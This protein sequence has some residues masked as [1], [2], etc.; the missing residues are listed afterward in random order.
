MTVGGEQRNEEGI[1]VVFLSDPSDIDNIWRISSYLGFHKTTSE[2]RY[3]P[4]KWL[5]N[6]LG[7]T[8]TNIYDITFSTPDWSNCLSPL[9]RVSW[10]ILHQLENQLKTSKNPL[11][12]ISKGLGGLIVKQ[13]CLCAPK[14]PQ[15]W[16]ILKRLAGLVFYSCPHE[17][18]SS[19]EM[20]EILM[21]VQI[22]EP[23]D[24]LVLA[25]QSL[26][27]LNDEFKELLS[28]NLIFN[29][30]QILSFG[31]ASKLSSAI[32]P[33]KISKFNFGDNYSLVGK[34]FSNITSVR[35]PEDFGYWK[36]LTLIRNIIRKKKNFQENK[37]EEN[38]QK[39]NKNINFNNL[40][41]N[42]D[43]RTL[44]II[45]GDYNTSD[46]S[47]YKIIYQEIHF[48]SLFE[49]LVKACATICENLQTPIDKLSNLIKEKKIKINMTGIKFQIEVAKFFLLYHLQISPESHTLIKIDYLN[50]SNEN[51]SLDSALVLEIKS[52]GYKEQLLPHLNKLA[53]L[54]QDSK[55]SVD[56]I[57]RIKDILNQKPKISLLGRPNSGK[58]TLINGLCG[59][60]WFSTASS[61]CTGTVS[62]LHVD[63]APN[64]STDPCIDLVY[65]S[66]D[67]L[68]SSVTEYVTQYLQRG[69]DNDDLKNI[70]K[71]FRDKYDEL[72][73]ENQ[74]NRVQRLS[75]KKCL[76]Q[77]SISEHVSLTSMNLNCLLLEKIIIHSKTDKL[78]PWL[79]DIILC[80]TPGLF[81]RLKQ[82]DDGFFP[83]TDKR[84]FDAA[85]NSDV[86]IYL[87]PHQDI[88]DELDIDLTK[89]I[90]RAP[91][92]KGLVCLT[93]FD[94]AFAAIKQQTLSDILENKRNRILECCR[95]PNPPGL[96]AYILEL[97]NQYVQ[98]KKNRTKLI[99]E[100]LKR[101]SDVVL[102]HTGK[103][104]LFFINNKNQN[105][106][107]NETEPANEDSDDSSD[108]F[109]DDDHEDSEEAS[110]TLDEYFKNQSIVNKADMVRIIYCASLE[111]SLAH[112]FLEQV[113]ELLKVS[114]FNKI[115][116]SLTSLS[117]IIAQ[118]IHNYHLQI[119]RLQTN[120]F[121]NVDPLATTP[122]TLLAE[123]LQS[124]LGF[125]DGNISFP[126]SDQNH[127]SVSTNFYQREKIKISTDQ[128]CQNLENYFAIK[129]KQA[130]LA[131]IQP[132]KES[133]LGKLMQ[134]TEKLKTN[135]MRIIPDVVINIDPI[136]IS[137]LTKLFI[138]EFSVCASQSKISSWLGEI[139]AQ[140][141]G[142]IRAE[143]EAKIHSFRPLRE[144]L[145]KNPTAT[146]V[147]FSKNFLQK[148]S[149]ADG[150]FKEKANTQVENIVKQLLLEAT[151]LRDEIANRAQQIL[152]EHL[153]QLDSTPLIQHSS[154]NACIQPFVISEKIKTLQR[155]LLALKSVH[156]IFYSIYVHGITSEQYCSVLVGSQLT[157]AERIYVSSIFNIL[158]YF[159]LAP[160]SLAMQNEQRNSTSVALHS[161][162]NEKRVLQGCLLEFQSLL[163]ANLPDFTVTDESDSL[164]FSSL[165]TS[166]SAVLLLNF[167]NSEF[168]IGILTKNANHN[169]FSCF[170][171][172]TF[173]SAVDDE[174]AAA[175]FY[176]KSVKKR[177]AIRNRH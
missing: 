31:E 150:L 76:T 38:Q 163:R 139:P 91:H 162:S 23:F 61:E 21:K 151:Q 6:D 40:T 128:F 8:N 156:K 147:I 105:G 106:N 115:Y 44:T 37:N 5:L 81:S 29:S 64:S 176:A 143:I 96:S 119:A 39:T 75:G 152:Q 43:E 153:L 93:K 9:I 53:Q 86:W 14:V 68:D 34:T 114:T 95:M 164:A 118:Q 79:E 135:W 154:S 73:S 13:M 158:L 56:C 124:Q 110:Y 169:T 87:T 132:L 45:Q 80:D 54:L 16:E 155:K 67:E 108:P 57:D 160:S 111:A 19:S 51:K 99:D 137:D 89:V 113:G 101:L 55:V 1:D 129:L 130:L 52:N 136:F 28:N 142:V 85:E 30:L 2:E 148:R 48:E 145:A 49:V 26:L 97:A 98:A 7:N 177:L 62:E 82:T 122:T 15:F 20:A 166:V 117:S 161:S 102:T 32:I 104:G 41:I 167:V 134:N 165:L 42:I 11:I 4:S 112:S 144:F 77:E 22:Q 18:G 60:S 27:A 59:N 171:E 107:E 36:V 66:K 70:T 17:C 100:L 78:R 103:T 109:G 58:S 35:S 173:S 146:Q 121:S 12:I 159:F 170:H 71:T 175:V 168:T 125:N 123:S 126:S 141:K 74:T 140:L 65:I 138:N 157:N 25:S 10:G 94:Y 33:K 133:A 84:A 131:A 149:Q 47:L 174:K 72:T 24:K 50:K 46:P 88:N 172:N 92:G 90:S 83:L 116:H 69:K 3:W 127:Q 63:K 120:E